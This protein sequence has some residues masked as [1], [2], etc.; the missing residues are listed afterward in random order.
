MVHYAFPTAPST[1]DM[2]SALKTSIGRY[3]VLSEIGRG[4]MGTVYKACDPQIDRVVAV[5]TIHLWGIGPAERDHYLARFLQEARTAGRL[6]HPS[7][8]S[9]FDVGEDDDCTPYIVMEYVPGASLSALLKQGKL[10]LKSALLLGEQIAEAL[11]MIHAHGVIHRDIKPDNILV[12]NEGRAKIADFGIARFDQSQLTTIAQIV[13]S[14]A[15]MAPELL[16]GEPADARSDIFSLGVVLYAAI[17]GHR[18]FQGNTT[19]T[20]CF[21]LVNRDPVPVSSWSVELPPELDKLLGRALAKNP[22]ERFQTASEVAQALR[23]VREACELREQPLDG[24]AKIL[25]RPSTAS[26]PLNQSEV[27]AESDSMLEM[28]GKVLQGQQKAPETPPAIHRMAESVPD[29]VRK[30]HRKFLPEIAVAAVLVLSTVVGV[31]LWNR[32]RG[33]GKRHSSTSEERI[34]AP[35]AP[36]TSTDI[37]PDLAVGSEPKPESTGMK[38]KYLHLSPDRAHNHPGTKHPIPAKV[39]SSASSAPVVKNGSAATGDSV[40][41]AVLEIMIYHSFRDAQASIS[42]DNHV[43]SSVELH[44]SEKRKAFLF[45]H[46][47]GVHSENL[48]LRPGPH[49]VSVKVQSASDKFDAAQTLTQSF[50]AGKNAIFLLKCDKRHDKLLLLK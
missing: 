40:A 5:K 45:K 25:N 43:V 13:G 6:V 27:L 29:N 49:T 30:S 20:V 21:K 7:I 16:E 14:P 34:V 23:L 17:S 3:Q 15:Y 33:K 42:V 44:S 41:P 11:Q 1:V 28:V 31:T 4:S 10:P 19:A 37:S 46:A 2:S 9:V 48:N 24:I 18:P 22:A 38:P 12:T 35:P 36:L 32:E 39:S 47:E 8:V 26:L 50:S